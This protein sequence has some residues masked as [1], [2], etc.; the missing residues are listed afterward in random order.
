MKKKT[1][2]TAISLLSA[3]A[4]MGLL[5][6]STLTGNA[7]AHGHLILV[8]DMENVNPISVVLGHTN[9]PAFGIEPGVHDGMHGVEVS[10]EDA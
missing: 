10:L 6:A 5:V 4:A 9:E 3:L 2:T 1:T 7:Y 8:P